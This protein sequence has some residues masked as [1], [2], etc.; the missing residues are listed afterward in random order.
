VVNGTGRFH[1]KNGETIG[2][3]CNY[4]VKLAE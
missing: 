4:S 2:D 3:V 1:F